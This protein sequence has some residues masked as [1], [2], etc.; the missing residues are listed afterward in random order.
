MIIAL[1]A[2]GFHLLDRFLIVVRLYEI[3]KVGENEYRCLF[4]WRGK[5]REGYFYY[6]GILPDVLIG[7]V[8]G[9][10]CWAELWEIEIVGN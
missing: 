4:F 1:I 8:I 7:R 6:E 10:D 2:A 9:V 3:E 5:L